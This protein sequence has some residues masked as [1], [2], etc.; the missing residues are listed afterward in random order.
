MHFQKPFYLCIA[1]IPY[2]FVSEDAVKIMAPLDCLEKQMPHVPIWEYI[3]VNLPQNRSPR[4]VVYNPPDIEWSCRIE[5]SSCKIPKFYSY[6]DICL[7]LSEQDCHFSAHFPHTE[8]LIFV[9][10]ACLI[11]LSH[12][13]IVPWRVY[14]CLFLDHVVF[15]CGFLCSRWAGVAPDSS[16]HYL[17]STR[18][19]RA[20][21]KFTAP[22][23]QIWYEAIALIT[24]PPIRQQWETQKP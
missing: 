4:L 22:S 21:R 15:L 5:S 19:S 11:S 16:F 20:R 6:A 10:H 8:G 2:V 14:R 17:N 7:C 1:L 24:V 12:G 9:R 3:G 13:G 18:V 23:V